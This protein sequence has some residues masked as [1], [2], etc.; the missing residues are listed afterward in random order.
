MTNGDSEHA[1]LSQ[2]FPREREDY[3]LAHTGESQFLQLG[4]RMS[5]L[6][7]QKISEWYDWTDSL[8][9]SH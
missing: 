4:G 5:Y 8:T 3:G 2:L 9:H 7:R 1:I 6:R